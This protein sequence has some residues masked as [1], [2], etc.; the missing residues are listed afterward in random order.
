MASEV[1]LTGN[2]QVLRRHNK[3]NRE[4]NIDTK[5]KKKKIPGRKERATKKRL[6]RPKILGVMRFD[7]EH[8]S[9]RDHPGGKPCFKDAEL[10][11]TL[12]EQ[13]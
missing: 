13:E 9:I 12:G 11:L 7:K 10:P 1:L 4:H 6:K 5:V 3:I 2:F 8:V